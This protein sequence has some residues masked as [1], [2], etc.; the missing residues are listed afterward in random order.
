MFATKLSLVPNPH[1]DESTVAAL[2][3][4]GDPELGD[5]RITAEERRLVRRLV[6]LLEPLMSDE[7][8]MHFAC[9]IEAAARRKRAVEGAGGA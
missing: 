4:D 1:N 7:L 6:A 5:A 9:G 8:L 2:V 3:A